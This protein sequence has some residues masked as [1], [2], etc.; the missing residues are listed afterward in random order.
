[1][2][3]SIEVLLE[4]KTM[5]ISGTVKKNMYL[6]LREKLAMKIKLKAV[7][8]LTKMKNLKKKTGFD[9]AK[10]RANSIKKNK[11]SISE[12]NRVYLSDYPVKTTIKAFYDPMIPHF[13]PKFVFPTISPPFYF[14]SAPILIG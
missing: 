6:L 11:K 7:C 2:Q 13:T 1:M 14:W 4:T 5:C 9:F 8:L 10:K 12:D 3:D